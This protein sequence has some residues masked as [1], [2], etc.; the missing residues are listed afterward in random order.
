VSG[1]IKL[2]DEVLMAMI[3]IVPGKVNTENSPVHPGNLIGYVLRNELCN[4]G[5]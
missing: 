4:E 3:G 1:Y 2:T 5:N